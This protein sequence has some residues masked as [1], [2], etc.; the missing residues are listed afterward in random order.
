MAWWIWAS[1]A[2]QGINA[3]Q[4]SRARE[5]ALRNQAAIAEV[6]GKI[7]MTNARFSARMQLKSGREMAVEVRKQSRRDV[8]SAVVSVAGQGVE[9]SGSPM[10]A[11]GEKI[12][13]DELN[14]ARVITN[15][16]TRAVSERLAG[17]AA[18]VGA[19]ARADALRGQADVEDATR[20]ITIMA[21]GA[22]AA[23]G[24][25]SLTG[26]PKSQN[27]GSPFDIYDQGPII[28]DLGSP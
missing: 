28:Q 24:F 26:G 14:A 20:F 16:E 4:G 7:A 8:G 5:A 21:I 27:Q 25:F 3:L 1:A 10:V 23:G 15:A 2:V 11:I 9:L 17:E 22:R 6:Q 12:R 13:S 18:R 19:E